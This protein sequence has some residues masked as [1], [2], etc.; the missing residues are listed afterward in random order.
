MIAFGF[1]EC[2]LAALRNAGIEL[3]GGQT[4][5]TNDDY[6]YLHPMD[7]LLATGKLYRND[8][9]MYKSTVRSPGYG[10]IYVA[11]VRIVGSNCALLAIKILQLLLFGASVY[12]LVFVAYG[13]LRSKV[14]A[15]VVAGI[16]GILP[17]SMG[18]LY[19]TLTEAV[20]PALVIIYV[21]LLFHASACIITRKKFLWYVFAALVF[22]WLFLTRPM[23]GLLGLAFPFY[24]WKDYFDARRPLR[25]A[26]F[27]GLFGMICISLTA[28]W[29]AR[30]YQ[31][32]GRYAGLHPVY[33]HEIPGTFRETHQSIWG[34]YKGWESRGSNFHET[35]VPLW[36][37]AIAGDTAVV[38]VDAVLDK[39]PND[40]IAFFG[41]KRLSDAFR[42]YQRATLAIKP[43]Y[44]H[45]WP[46]PSKPLAVEDSV[47]AQFNQLASEY[48]QHFWF[49]YYVRTP[50]KVFKNLA[51]HSNLSLYI[52]QT[53]WRGNMM[54]EILRWI[55]FLIHALA[56][57]LCLLFL[58][59]RSELRHKALFGVCV[60]IYIFYLVYVQRGIEE[61][62]TLPLLPL[63]LVGA[64][65]VVQQLL[66]K[67]FTRTR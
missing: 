30:N 18:F 62:Y 29:Q 46:M 12:C 37:R 36:E 57:V 9:E 43:W 19:Y 60:L 52:F 61:R 41:K 14:G 58:F 48:R 26:I 31:L 8:Y 50:L 11:A 63:I 54:M 3:R 13:L 35:M 51:F 53:S 47:I 7:N 66:K 49:T 17:F 25:F 5:V 6:S 2:N 27:L 28:L 24:L 59:F 65:Y 22:A 4:V 21:F 55:C 38:H 23:L 56:F 33:Q 1:N 42:L 44:D 32:T 45:E 16:Y 40:V 34:L 67:L 15:L 39:T 20:T 64:A 10:L